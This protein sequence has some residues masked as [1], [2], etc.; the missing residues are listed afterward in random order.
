MCSIT[1]LVHLLIFSNNHIRFFR[2]VPPLDSILD[3]FEPVNLNPIRNAWL[4]KWNILL[5][6]FFIK[7]RSFRKPDSTLNSIV[8]E[9]HSLLIITKSKNLFHSNPFLR[10][11]RTFLM[12]KNRNGSLY[13]LENRSNL[14]DRNNGR[15]VM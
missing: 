3:Q 13:L 9:R 10:I 7:G 6:S 12:L 14:L 4:R 15:C 11:N 2:V 8:S 5:I 1:S